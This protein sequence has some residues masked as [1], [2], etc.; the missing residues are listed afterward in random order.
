M[1]NLQ[2]F[3]NLV[4]FQGGLTGHMIYGGPNLQLAS[5]GGSLRLVRIFESQRQ[6]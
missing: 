2:L 3:S 6:L 1:C 4:T 5:F